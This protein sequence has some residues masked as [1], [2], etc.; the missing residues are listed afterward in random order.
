MKCVWLVEARA[1]IG[2]TQKEVSDRTNISR[3]HYT[4]IEQGVRRPSP[5]TAKTIGEVLNIDW[6]KFYESK[7]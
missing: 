4:N 3:S 1:K 7:S 2:L 5:E 6:Q